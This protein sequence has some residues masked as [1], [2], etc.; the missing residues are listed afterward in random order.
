MTTIAAL[1]GAG[2]S[3]T[4]ILAFPAIFLEMSVAVT[5]A[6]PTASPAV[7]CPAAVML[8]GVEIQLNV[9]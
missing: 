3:V 1:D 2:G 9:G 4:E 7:Y 8:P 6:L 5:T